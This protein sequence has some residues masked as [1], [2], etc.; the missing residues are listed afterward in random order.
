MIGASEWCWGQGGEVGDL[1]QRCG[2]KG[3]IRPGPGD[4]DS[5]LR[6]VTVGMDPKPIGF[7]RRGRAFKAEFLAPLQESW[8]GRKLCSKKA[9]KVCK[10]LI[11]KNRF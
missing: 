2:H 4:R 1:G 9:G 8:L 11:R 10:G 5:L 7:T 6:E 3:N